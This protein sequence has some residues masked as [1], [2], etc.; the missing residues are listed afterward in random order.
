MVSSSYIRALVRS[1]FQ[2][3]G[4]TQLNASAFDD[5]YSQYNKKGNGYYTKGPLDQAFK[6]QVRR[7]W[8]QEFKARGLIWRTPSELSLRRYWPVLYEVKRALSPSLQA[9]VDGI[10]QHNNQSAL[11]RIDCWDQIVKLANA[12]ASAIEPCM[13]SISQGRSWWFRFQQKYGNLIYQEKIWNMI[14][15]KA[16][17][18]S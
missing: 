17:I 1:Y 5:L 2:V 14:T 10:Y 11:R 16:H 7:Q 13:F 4:V 12:N 8:G 3:H 18:R 15:G 9:P 6:Y